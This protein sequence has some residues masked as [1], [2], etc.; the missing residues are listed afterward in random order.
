MHAA[1]FPASAIVH[2]LVSLSELQGALLLENFLMKVPIDALNEAPKQQGV[3]AHVR[4][5]RNE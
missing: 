1:F 3:C 4:R 2:A 5:K